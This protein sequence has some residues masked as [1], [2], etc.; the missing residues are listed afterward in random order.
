MF[1]KQP[2]HSVIRKRSSGAALV[3]TLAILILVTTL[4]LSMFVSVTSERSDTAASANQSDSKRLANMTVELVKSTITQATI[5]TDVTN[6]NHT[7]WA[8]QPGMIRTWTV[9]GTTPI[10]NRTFRLYSSGTIATLD[11]TGTAVINADI[12]DLATWK[13]GTTTSY[14]ALWCDLNA[15]GLNSSA[16]LVY[17]IV[18]PPTRLDANYGVPIDTSGTAS[19]DGTANGVQGFDITGSS[20]Y[21]GGTPSPTN[22]PAPMPVKWLYVLQNGEFI[23]PTSSGTNVVT[24]LD[25]SGTNPI[26]A[27]VAYWT[28]DE[29]CKVNINTASEGVFWQYPHS[30][31]STGTTGALVSSSQYS[32]TPGALLSGTGPVAGGWTAAHLALY[33]PGRN[34][35]QRYPGHPATTSLSPVLSG[36]TPITTDQIYA[37]VPRIQQGGSLGGTQFPANP[38][39]GYLGTGNEIIDLSKDVERLYTSPDELI[40]SGTSGSKR[41]LNNIVTAT[42]VSRRKFFLTASSRAP[43]TTLFETPRVSIWPTMTSSSNQDNFDTLL[44]FCA[45]LK[46]GTYYF[47]REQATD[48]T[49]D[50]TALTRNQQIYSYLQAMTSA[51]TAIPGFG[52]N[53][54]TKFPSNPSNPGNPSDR[55]QILTEIFDYIRSGP[56]LMGAGFAANNTLTIQNDSDFMKYSYAFSTGAQSIYGTNYVAPISITSQGPVSITGTTKGF[57]NGPYYIQQL[58][59]AFVCDHMTLTGTTGGSDVPVIDPAKVVAS[60]TVPFLSSTISYTVRAVPLV[61]LFRPT[62]TCD[63]LSA[64]NSNSGLSLNLKISPITIN[65]YG[66]SLPSSGGGQV[67]FP[68]SSTDYFYAGNGYGPMYSPA[69]LIWNANTV[70][71]TTTPRYAGGASTGNTVLSTSVTLTFD[72]PYLYNTGTTAA[73][74]FKVDPTKWIPTVTGTSSVTG[75]SRSFAFNSEGMDAVSGSASVFWPNDTACYDTTIPISYS[76]TSGTTIVQTLWMTAGPTNMTVNLCANNASKTVLQTASIAIPLGTYPV[77]HW[78]FNETPMGD[79]TGNS[80]ALFTGTSMSISQA[81][82]AFATFS[83]T[84][85]SFLSRLGVATSNTS[86]SNAYDPGAYV[87]VDGDVVISYEMLANSGY[88][89]DTRLAAIRGLTPGDVEL[90]STGSRSGATV[91]TGVQPKHQYA[92]CG[93]GDNALRRYSAGTL[94][95]GTYTGDPAGTRAL[96]LNQWTALSSRTKGVFQA[97]HIGLQIPGDW[98]NAFYDQIDGPF[99]NYPDTGLIG[100]GAGA[101]SSSMTVGGIALTGIPYSTSTRLLTGVGS[102]D[103]VICSESYSPNRQMYSPFQFGSLPSRVWAG[104]PWETLLFCPNPAATRAL[105]RGYS[106]TPKDYL[107]GDLFW[108]PIVD[109]YPISEAFSTAGKIN[110]NSAI[111]PFNYIQRKTGLWALLKSSRITAFPTTETNYKYTGTDIRKSFIYPIDVLETLK[112]MDDYV[113]T[114]GMFKSPTEIAEIF[115]VPYVANAVPAQSLITCSG[116]ANRES[117]LNNWWATQQFTGDNTREQPYAYLLPRLTTKSNTYTVHYR[118]QTLKK[119][120]TASNQNQWVE[121]QDQVVSEFRGSATIER[122]IDPN[123]STI[124][125]FAGASAPALTSGS[126]LAN[127]YRWRTVQQKQFIP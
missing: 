127:F 19:N 103:A 69:R 30:V 63:V 52:G 41:T 74:F 26:I 89:A 47:Q 20:G 8:S 73:C 77:P 16:A 111:A 93:T 45:T 51:T 80:N 119:I 114:N 83:G 82:T 71:D 2:S 18:T 110:L 32:S 126:N 11:T 78:N 108:M 101:F 100:S 98:D 43:E 68:C 1:M 85:S 54:E 94:I 113:A 59:I 56:N 17:P 66:N 27:R 13:T 10:G 15:P 40:Y 91:I 57:G 124:P 115:L 35:F 25:A 92:M 96:E 48:P 109:P 105:H 75:S 125:D 60:G 72:N 22:N 95:S 39:V 23:A 7:A 104:D 53:F 122:Y 58:G 79:G 62:R 64:G 44:N 81:K 34:E 90:S 24:V 87:G 38:L 36:S 70:Y 112:G 28:D 5:D 121:G 84:A 65:P 120:K 106:T 3:I 67:T 31:G 6:G 86:T 97:D 117:K 50:W 14:N 118:V 102:I 12:T 9:N 37:L 76:S 123:D 46:S 29:T 55:D 4:V 107:L 33:Q 88:K 61:Q 116:S 42:D 99:L 49:H 21:L